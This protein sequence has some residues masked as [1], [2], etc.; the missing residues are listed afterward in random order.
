ML[1]IAVL[2][3]LERHVVRAVLLGLLRHQA[4][5]G[6][7]THGRRIERAVGLAEVDDF[8]VDAGK[9]RLRVHGLDVLGPAVGAVHLAARADHRRHRGVHDHV[10]GR[11]EVG[12][13]PSRIH[14][15]QLGAVV[16]DVVDVLDDLV[17]LRGWQRL[18]LVV[19]IDHPVVDVHTQFIEHLLVLGEGVLVEDLHRVAEDDGVGDLH[20]R[21]LDV[22]GEHHAGLVR[23]L[24]LLLVELAQGFLAHEHAP[25]TSPSP[26]AVSGLST[27]VSPLLV[28]SSIRTSRARSS[29]IDFSPW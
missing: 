16:V 15:R 14:H 28:T 18:D 27:S 23:I 20:H 10:A 7:G 5:I 9:G 24:D 11:M 25:M 8:L 4:D 13:T 29:V 1:A 17:A 6:D 2:G 19:E 12:D 22:Q 26:N 21:R 3:N